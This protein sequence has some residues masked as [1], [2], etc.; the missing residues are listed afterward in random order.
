MIRMSALTVTSHGAPLDIAVS[1]T[2]RGATPAEIDRIG[3]SD[4]GDCRNNTSADITVT[5]KDAEAM[6]CE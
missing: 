1:L 5:V 3:V 6:C 2:A 4:C